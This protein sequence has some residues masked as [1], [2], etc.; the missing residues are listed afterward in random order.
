MRLIGST[1]EMTIADLMVH[2]VGTGKGLKSSDVTL[3]RLLRKVGYQTIHVGKGHFGPDDSEGSEP[4][5]L[6][7]DVNVGGAAFGAPGSYYGE[8]NLW[9][10]YQ[11]FAPCRASLEEIPWL[12][13]VFD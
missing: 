11:A 9:L 6:G 1:R 4:L 8:E 12:G 10:G 2:R 5:N 13:N 3:P 7:F